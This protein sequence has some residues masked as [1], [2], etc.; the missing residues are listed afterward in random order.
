MNVNITLALTT[1]KWKEEKRENEQKTS[2]LTTKIVRDDNG[3]EYSLH[4][5]TLK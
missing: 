5:N 3:S 4:L 2:R 1:R